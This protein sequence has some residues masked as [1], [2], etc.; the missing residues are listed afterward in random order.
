MV[1]QLRNSRRFHTNV[2]L[3]RRV[4][5]HMIIKYL[6]YIANPLVRTYALDNNNIKG[7][8][9]GIKGR[10]IITPEHVGHEVNVSGDY[11]YCPGC[12]RTITPKQNT[13]PPPKTCSG[14]E[15]CANQLS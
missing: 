5:Q 3:T 6:K 9:T 1:T 11:E 13:V 12:G 2:D 14:E 7:T 8:P 10:R 15:N 4:Q